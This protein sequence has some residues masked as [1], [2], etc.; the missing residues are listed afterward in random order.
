M[1]MP[2]MRPYLIVYQYSTPMRNV[3]EN[4]Q[5]TGPGMP[6][7][8]VHVIKGKIAQ[9]HGCAPAQVIIL[10]IIELDGDLEIQA[11]PIDEPPKAHHSLAAILNGTVQPDSSSDH[12]VDGS[13]SAVFPEPAPDEA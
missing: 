12:P 10:N 3:T 13:A 1:T 5:I 4:L 8:A 11:E 9:L 2:T 6:K 7:E